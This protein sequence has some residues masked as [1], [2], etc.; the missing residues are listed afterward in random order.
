MHQRLFIGLAIALITIIAACQGPPPT[1]IILV[2]TATPD[3]NSANPTPTRE[4]VEVQAVTEEPSASPM[5][6]TIPQPTATHNGVATPTITQIQVAEQVFE[7]GRMF[8]LQ[9]T[10]QVWVM[11]ITGEGEGTWQVYT[12]TFREGD[13]E[14]DP[15][16]VPPSGL[17]QPKRGFGK[18]WRDNPDIREVLGWAVTP[19]FGYVTRYEYHPGQ[20][21]NTPGY[22]VLFSLY[23][24]G[25]R[26]NEADSSWQLN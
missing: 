8:W 6:Q 1:Q 16:L 23:N 15:D 7:K 14:S 25:F 11:V 13:P 24:E 5:Q 21:A 22:H 19:E 2:V 20:Q 12:N 9:P 3:T 4:T 18:L 17:E 10:D 26:F